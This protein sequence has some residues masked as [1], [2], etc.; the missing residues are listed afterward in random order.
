MHFI[1]FHGI[2][3]DFVLLISQ[4]P[5][6][7]TISPAL[8][9]QICARATGVGADGVMALRESE[10]ADFSMEL[11]NAD[12]SAPEMC[13][14]GIRCLVKYA[15]EEAGHRSNP[16]WVD[17]LAGPKSCAYS[18]D[19]EG[20]VSTVRVAMGQTAARPMEVQG[21]Q[22]WVVDVGNPHFV[23]FGDPGAR[24]RGRAQTLGSDL[25]SDSSFPE[26]ANIEMVHAVDRRTFEVIVYERGCGLTQACGTGA[27][28]VVAAA[29]AAGLADPDTDVRVQLPGGALT[30]RVSADGSE[31]SM[32]GPAVEVYRGSIKP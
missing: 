2:G 5:V 24:D 9:R 6:L 7:R 21:R 14:N 13:G 4:E 3:N 30:I 29:V 20:K 32:E 25:S 10:T 16:L 12:G 27:T 28:A 23:L 1:K 19:A 15:V 17:T 31:S 18:L 8:A 22:G 11:L 26:G